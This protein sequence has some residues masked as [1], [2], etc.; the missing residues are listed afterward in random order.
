MCIFYLGSGFLFLFQELSVVN[1]FMLRYVRF[2]IR[3][4][5]WGNTMNREK[6]LLLISYFRENARASLT[7]ISKK[8]NIPVSTIF[9]KLRDYEGKMIEKHTSLLDFRRLGFDVKAHLLFRVAKEHKEVFQSF[10]S[11]HARVNSLFRINNGFDFLVEAV[12]RDLDDLHAFFEEAQHF[13]VLERKEYFVLKDILR[14]AFLSHKPGYNM[15][16]DTPVQSIV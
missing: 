7:G 3:K 6:E 12:F 1:D 9:D 5:G 13:N 10:L 14:E 15:I 16:L 11:S 2:H 4:H 8:T